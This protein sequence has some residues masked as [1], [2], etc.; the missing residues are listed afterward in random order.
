MENTV[1]KGEIARYEQFLIFPQCFQKVCFRG[2]SKG[3]LVREWVELFNSLPND[4]I[5][6]WS[7]LK[8]F[9]EDKIKASQN[10]KF[11]LRSVE[12]IEGKEESAGDQHFLLL[13]NVFKDYLSLGR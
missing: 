9:A 12:N 4:R 2:A 10:M 11:V 13:H 7:K 5:L 1:G 8:A 3:V 6:N